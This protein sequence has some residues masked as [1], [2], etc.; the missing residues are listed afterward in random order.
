MEK[1][2]SKKLKI[3]LVVI[4]IIVCILI[5][6]V[7]RRAIILSKIDKKV[8]E[9]ENNSNN[10]YIKNTYKDEKNY[11]AIIERYIKDDVSKLVVGKTT[12]DG[13][14]AKITEITYPEK[15]KMFTEVNG[16]KVMNVYNEKAAVRGSHIE[17]E[18]ERSYTTLSNPGY[19]M[20]INELIM[21]AIVT[22]IKSARIDG[23]D[24]YEL[25]STMNSNFLYDT[26]TTKM[27]IYVEKE[28]GLTTKIVEE[29]NENGEIKQVLKDFEYQFNNVTDEDIREPDNSEYKMRENS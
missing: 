19:S 6:I 26:N 27:S 3:V 21:N 20:A 9:L 29:V 7:A 18:T 25:S 11:T 10:F 2:K 17:K 14:N 5:A 8:T 12:L 28:T 15:R 22:S 23:K 13:K 4:A 16:I 1:T 24:C